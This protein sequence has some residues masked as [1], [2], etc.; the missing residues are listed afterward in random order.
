MIA[1]QI[2]FDKLFV[3]VNPFIG[4]YFA[5]LLGIEFCGSKMH[6]MKCI[7]WNAWTEM[8]RMKCIEWNAK[9]WNAKNKTQSVQ[10]ISKLV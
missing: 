1:T 3:Y 2:Y 10:R 8:H 6:R 7:E 4:I 5:W 9:E